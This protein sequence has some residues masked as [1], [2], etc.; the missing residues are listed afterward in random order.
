MKKALLFNIICFLL[1]A[2]G[3]KITDDQVKKLDQLTQRVDSSVDILIN[4][5]DSNKVVEL[6]DEF[7][8]KKSFFENEMK[9]TIDRATIFIIDNY[10]RSKKSMEYIRMNFAPLIQEAKTM[11]LQISDLKHDID[12]RLIDQE[13]FE[14]YYDLENR[15]SLELESAV[16]QIKSIYLKMNEELV[17]KN[18]QIDSII[19]V[20]NKKV[21]A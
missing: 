17:K 8:M 10:M 13:Q 3:T 2:C 18:P 21:D 5:I 9:D 7:F 4:Q 11:Q 16:E 1:V 20:Y 12:N 19:N 14:K 6:T 15:N